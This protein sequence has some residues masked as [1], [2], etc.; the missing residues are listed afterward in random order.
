MIYDDFSRENTKHTW[1]IVIRDLSDK[2]KNEQSSK[3]LIPKVRTF[4]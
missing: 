4:I 2:I 3:W 1:D